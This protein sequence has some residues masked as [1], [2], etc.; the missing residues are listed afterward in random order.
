MWV[1]N[2]LLLTMAI[3]VVFAI[4]VLVIAGVLALLGIDYIV[5]NWIRR[6]VEGW[7]NKDN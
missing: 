2:A 4:V 7:L 5:K 3:S 1:I 6:K